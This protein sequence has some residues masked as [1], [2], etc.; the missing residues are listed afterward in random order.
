MYSYNP[1]QA[2]TLLAEAGWK[3]GKDGILQKNGKPFQLTM[4][5]DGDAF[6][7]AK[8]M[9]EVI[10]AELKEIG[11]GVEIRLID[12]GAWNDAL[13]KKQFDLAINLSWGSPYDPHLSLKSMFHSSD[14]PVEH[15][16]IYANPKLDKLIDN[17]L[18]T[19]DEKQRQTLYG[20][21]QKFMDENVAVIPVVYSSRVYAVGSNVNGFQLA[22]TEYELN[23]EGV[24]LQ[25]R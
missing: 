22:G 16:G 9:A 11:V 19:K 6:P 7:Q 20:D 5:V 14:Q 3:P 12:S 4:I 23:L 13:M 1:E 18:V 17:V 25:G 10:Q 2:K 15:G 8:S 24:T 21:I